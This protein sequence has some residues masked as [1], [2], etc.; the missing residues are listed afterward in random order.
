MNFNI[1]S[2][3]NRILGLVLLFMLISQ[4]QAQPQELIIGFA[5]VWEGNARTPALSIDIT[6]NGDPITNATIT[7][8]SSGLD[9]SKK[10]FFNNSQF[11]IDRIER[12]ETEY[13]LVGFDYPKTFDDITVLTDIKYDQGSTSVRFTVPAVLLG[14]PSSSS[15]MTYIFMM[16][17]GALSGVVLTWYKLVPKKEII[18]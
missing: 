9:V 8:N 14:L 18:K 4:V 15:A 2:T 12:G 3:I 1:L 7:V 11:H 5:P 17:V 10:S 6:N 13:F 16:L